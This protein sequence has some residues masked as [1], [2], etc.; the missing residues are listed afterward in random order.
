MILTK[1]KILK[2]KVFRFIEQ[3][4]LNC[5]YDQAAVEPIFDKHWIWSWNLRTLSSSDV[6][7]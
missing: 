3:E 4:V 2:V 1:Q 5:C 6:P 7:V